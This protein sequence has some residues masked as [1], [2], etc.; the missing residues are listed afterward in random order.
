MADNTLEIIIQDK[1]TI[2]GGTG[3]GGGGGGPAPRGPRGGPLDPVQEVLKEI[4][5]DRQRML[6]K[7]TRANFMQ[8]PAEV[9]P[10]EGPTGS[11]PSVMEQIGGIFNQLG[12]G[13][14]G[15][16]FGVASSVAGRAGGVG[17]TAAGAGAVAGGTLAATG[18]VGAAITAVVTA[19]HALGNAMKEQIEL[20]GKSAS[21]VAG[22]DMKGFIKAQT[23]YISESTIA[24]VTTMGLNKA[25]G[26]LINTVFE[27]DQTLMGTAKRFE[28][29]SGSLATAM[30]VAETR[31][32]LGEMRRG[33]RLGDDLARF[34]DARSRISEVGQ[35]AMTRVLQV[36]LPTITR[37]LEKVADGVEAV[38]KRVEAIRQ[39]IANIPDSMITGLRASLIGAPL[40]EI[41]DRLRQIARNT[42][43]RDETGDDPLS[44]LAAMALADAFPRGLIG[45]RA[46]TAP[47]TPSTRPGGG[48]GFGVP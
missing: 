33:A 25:F 27:F 4:E 32:Q 36:V 10:A 9:L 1:G 28:G 8:G 18:L 47:Q 37:L 24:T 12:L 20:Y 22:L 5:R 39:E 3:G 17:G 6:V 13:N 35:D 43:P 7:A 34:V 31:H 16:L 14:V 11:G 21:A 15:Q 19:S 30:A 23:D 46:F 48:G 40:A 38:E 44:E 2:G 42:A 26:A 45:G 41:L 29:F